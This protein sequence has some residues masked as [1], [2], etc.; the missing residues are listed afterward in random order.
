[1]VWHSTCSDGVALRLG[2][3]SP[4]PYSPGRRSVAIFRIRISTF[5][6]TRARSD[7]AW[8]SNPP[9]ATPEYGIS[10]L[11]EDRDSRDFPEGGSVYRCATAMQKPLGADAYCPSQRPLPDAVIRFQ[12][13]APFGRSFTG[14]TN[15]GGIFT[16]NLPA[17]H[18][19]VSLDGC[20]EYPLKQKYPLELTVNSSG[21]PGWNPP[22]LA[23]VVDPSGACWQTPSLGL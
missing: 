22:S 15:A 7:A 19:S 4:N 18:Y 1:M 10:L 8:R 16:V 23:W 11:V 17:G 12:E 2:F 21:W 6:S 20:R 14:R 5:L 3:L 13:T 9:R